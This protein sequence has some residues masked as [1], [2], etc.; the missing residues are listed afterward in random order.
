MCR[1]AERVRL[2]RVRRGQDCD[3]EPEPLRAEHRAASHDLVPAHLQ[4]AVP[5]HR[6]RQDAPKTG[7]SCNVF[8]AK[9]RARNGKHENVD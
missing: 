5:M 4:G 8:G 7:S 2:G 1:R 3:P 6:Q 9:E